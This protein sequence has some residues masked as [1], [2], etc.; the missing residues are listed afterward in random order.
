MILRNPAVRISL[1]L[2]LATV[3]LLLIADL[4]GF[5]P[6]R[7]QA[8]L[9]AR[10][11]LSESLALKISTAAERNDLDFI[12]NTLHS[13]VEQ[14]RDISSAAIRIKNGQLLAIAG[15]HLAHWQAPPREKSTPTNVQVPIY[16]GEVQ[17]ATVELHFAPLWI[18]DLLSGFR[19]SFTG[20]L[21]FISLS[22]FTC[23]FFI[24]KKTLRLLDPSEVIPEHIKDAFDVLKE[25]V[26]ILDDKEQVVMANK[27]FAR[28]FAKE[29]EQLIGF[30]G[31]ELGWRRDRL[32]DKSLPFP[33]LTV[34]QTGENQFGTALLLE[35]AESK[36]RKFS[37][38]A[39]AIRDNKGKLQGV[40]VTFDDVTEIEE[41]N[42]ELKDYLN[43]LQVSNKEILEK[44]DELK[45]LAGHDPMTMC[46]NRRELNNR[47][48]K[49]F[50]SAMQDGTDLSCIM[51]D[52]DHFKSVNDKYGHST[53]D[54]VIKCVADVLKSNLR[55]EDL[56]ARYGG[57]EFCIVT[58]LQGTKMINKIANRMRLAIKNNNCAGVNVTACFGIKSLTP[59]MHSPENM[60]SYAD[61]ALYIA[62]ESGR[63]KVVFWDDLGT[64]TALDR[65]EITQ[66]FEGNNANLPSKPQASYTSQTIKKPALDA[67]AEVGDLVN[68]I[69]ELEGLAAKRSQEIKN[70]TFYDKK[71]GLPSR[72]LFFDR[73]TQVLARC[74]RN[75]KFIAILSMNVEMVQRV[76]ETIGQTSSDQLLA[77]CAKRLT[78]IFRREDTIAIMKDLSSETSVSVLND[79]EFGVLVTDLKK[80]DDVT[81]VV[82]RVLDSFT[83]PFV[84]EENEIFAGVNIGISVFPRD[85]ETAEELHKKALAASRHISKKTGRNKYRFYSK[86]IDETTFRHLQI[87]S[88]LRQA[89][90][91]DEL[92]LNYQPQIDAATGMV[93]CVEALA[94]WNNRQ[95]GVIAPDEFIKIAE[96]TGQ[97]ESIGKW[98][99]ASAFRQLSV[100]HETGFAD[101]NM[102][103][104]FSA[105]QFQQKNLVKMILQLAD[106]YAI[107]CQSFEIELTETVMMQNSGH[108]LKAI[109][110]LHQHGFK[111]TID[112]FGTGYSSLN[113]IKNLPISCIKIDKEFVNNIASEKHSATLLQSIINMAHD[114]GFKVIA[115][116][117]EEQAQADILVKFGCD[118]LQGYLFSKPLSGR[119]TIEFLR[120]GSLKKLVV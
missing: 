62:K 21:I 31:S 108:A 23:F 87:E 99:F 119:E 93:S 15:N 115:E 57:E 86:E 39:S 61:K 65:H 97:I 96:L 2:V 36:I 75:E 109:K 72:L 44:S 78:D 83:M 7:S 35:T 17:W 88:N 9:E 43:K 76:R 27:S 46:L 67:A 28:V 112:D 42:I 117:V 80:I 14:N 59:D 73:F 116:G 45:F 77:A 12:R 71:T 33:W 6:D 20:L 107:P 48:N 22:C 16:N 29:T 110:E 81:W 40:L 56:L 102:A 98:I 79:S 104:N 11:S 10:K 105:M 32:E 100:L 26:I 84:I 54:V 60:I 4:I 106:E 118:K 52:I 94:R 111:I 103:I 120:Q 25:G 89:I 91:K 1:S 18:D 13:V 63:D 90:D 101:L 55:Q 82:K 92:S 69:R 70:Y 24:I 74:K 66:S 49:L 58:K 51:V 53:G 85:G 95:L 3:S 68:R 47:F 5:I 37:V 64:S 113:Y 38:N 19:N 30:K 50:S 34:L 114:L 41:K 8:V